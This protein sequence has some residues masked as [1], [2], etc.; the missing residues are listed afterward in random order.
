MTKEKPYHIEIPIGTP[1]PFVLGICIILLGTV[2][3]DG[4]PLLSQTLEPLE[5]PE[6]PTV[7]ELIGIAKER[8]VGILS[9]YGVSKKTPLFKATGVRHEI[10]QRALEELI[11]EGTVVEERVKNAK[12]I[13]LVQPQKIR[14]LK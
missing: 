2:E 11:N 8:I 14:L 6:T 7:E 10:F 12:Y 4:V 1:D 3:T 5:P 9:M 13:K